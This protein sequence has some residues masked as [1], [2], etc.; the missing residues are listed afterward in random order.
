M[1]IRDG[2][3]ALDLSVFW[4]NSLENFGKSVSLCVQIL[5]RRFKLL[6]IE[7]TVRFLED[8]TQTSISRAARSAEFNKTPTE[9]VLDGK[10][11]SRSMEPRLQRILVW[12]CF[13]ARMHRVHTR[14][15][16]ARTT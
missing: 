16:G 1:V 9:V 10:S 13:Y 14:V 3:A 11:Q 4:K 7:A 5:R 6:P 15:T 2:V 8:G 12:T